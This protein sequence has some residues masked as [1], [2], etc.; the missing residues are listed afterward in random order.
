MCATADIG[1]VL[2][3]RP[4][5]APLP[6]QLRPSILTNLDSQR[7]GKIQTPPEVTAPPPPAGLAPGTLPTK[8]TVRELL[9][10]RNTPSKMEIGQGVFLQADITVR[11]GWRVD[12]VHAGGAPPPPSPAGV[13]VSIVFFPDLICA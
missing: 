9:E 7:L 13:S 8:R 4:V 10:T 6:L 11:G 3:G 1:A 12:E 2:P 5:P